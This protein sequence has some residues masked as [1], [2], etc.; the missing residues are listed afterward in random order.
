MTLFYADV[1]FYT[2]GMANHRSYVVAAKSF[3]CVESVLRKRFG[4]ETEAVSIQLL[5]DEANVLR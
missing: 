5:A 2:D 4:K 3:S 1:L